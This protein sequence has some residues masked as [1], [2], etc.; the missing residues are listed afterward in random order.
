MLSLLPSS[1]LVQKV[2]S[3]HFAKDV[4]KAREKTHKAR[5]SETYSTDVSIRLPSVV[6]LLVTQSQPQNV[7]VLNGSRGGAI[8]LLSSRPPTWQNQLKPPINRK[9]WFEHG[10]PLSAIKEDVDYLRNFFLRFEQLNLSIKDPKKWAWLITWGNR[11]LSTVLFYAQSIQNLPSGWSNAVDIKL[12]VAHQYFLDPYRTAEA[13]NK[14]KEA[15]DWQN[16]VAT[17]FA[18]WLNRKIQ[19]NDKMFTPLVEHTKLWKELMLR[20]LREQNQMVKA[21]LAVTKEEQA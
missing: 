10:I 21:V 11:I 20:Q 19:G 12:K 15:S 5:L 1:S 14:P 3:S 6:R 8:R 13:F 18:Y 7:S 17:D 2:Y 4:R 16:V 9:S